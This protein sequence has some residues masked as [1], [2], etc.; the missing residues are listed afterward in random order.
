MSDLKKKL[1]RDVR[2]DLRKTVKVMSA[3]AKA[4][5]NSSNNDSSDSSVVNKKKRK[6]KQLKPNIPLPKRNKK[7]HNEVA[8]KER[9]FLT[10]EE[11][12]RDL[13]AWANQLTEY[14]PM[15]LPKWK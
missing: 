8:K 4:S 13:E 9:R 11:R 15:K 1:D 3:V 7:G 12:Q 2:K 6:E 14:E 5:I 10:Q